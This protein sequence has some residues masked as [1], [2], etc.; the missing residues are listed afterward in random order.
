MS[1]VSSG[2]V[3]VRGNGPAGAP[4]P[5]RP[6]SPDWSS[7]CTPRSVSDL[8]DGHAWRHLVLFVSKND[9][10]AS[11]RC[12]PGVD[13]NDPPTS[14]SVASLLLLL[15]AQVGLGTPVAGRVPAT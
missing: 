13:K 14:Q 9:L 3:A 6:F 5:L 12:F 2:T 4:Q 8:V 11:A 15:M 1:F 10:K 7:Y